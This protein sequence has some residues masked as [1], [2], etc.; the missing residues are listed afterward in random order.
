MF[1]GITRYTERAASLRIW[2]FRDTACGGF[3]ARYALNSAFVLPAG[4][5]NLML[6]LP[7]LLSSCSVS[8]LLLACPLLR[9][10]LQRVARSL[11]QDQP[12]TPPANPG[13]SGHAGNARGSDTGQSNH[14]RPPRPNPGDTAYP[15]DTRGPANSGGQSSR[16]RT[17]AGQHRE[18]LA[19]RQDRPLRRCA[20]PRAAHLGARPTPR[21]RRG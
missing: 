10:P 8:S 20:P 5:C 9:L 1:A 16:E 3:Y 17:A 6:R 4:R 13:N 12:A 14:T 18:L 2:A 15:G 21:R 11:G 7:R 19:L